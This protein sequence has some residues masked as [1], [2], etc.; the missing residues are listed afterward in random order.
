MSQATQA[1]STAD[2]RQV[3]ITPDATTLKE[4][5]EAPDGMAAGVA[6]V[7]SSNG[8][9]MEEDVVAAKG[10]AEE[11]LLS[12]DVGVTVA[13]SFSGEFC[14]PETEIFYARLSKSFLKKEEAVYTGEGVAGAVASSI[15]GDAFFYM[16]EDENY[17][18][19]A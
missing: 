18:L 3:I 11:A 16:A 2:F 7:L 5:T 1:C 13:E 8:E 17:E 15:S 12:K 19:T 10:D 9:V 6:A 14:T 4:V